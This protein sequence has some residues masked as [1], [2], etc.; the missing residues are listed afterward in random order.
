MTRNK[1]PQ[2]RAEFPP[3]SWPGRAPAVG[4]EVKTDQVFV[5]ARRMFVV[6]AQSWPTEVT[7]PR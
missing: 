6:R 5:S 4:D 7:I 3:T 2:R 1:R